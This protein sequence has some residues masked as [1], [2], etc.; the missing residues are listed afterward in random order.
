[1]IYKSE[2]AKATL[3]II[4]EEYPE[5]P[6]RWDNLGTMICFHNR[7]TI[8]DKHNYSSDTFL[9]DL[10]SEYGYIRDSYFDYWKSGPGYTQISQWV[11]SESEK[12]N[13]QGDMLFFQIGEMITEIIDKRISKEIEKHFIILPLYLYDHTG[14]TISTS[15]FSCPWDSGQVGFIFV[16]KDKVKKHFGYKH[17]TKKRINNIIKILKDEV[18]VY[19]QYLTGDIYGFKYEYKYPF[20]FENEGSSCWGFYGDNWKEN[21]LIDYLP[22]DIKP[23]IDNL[24]VE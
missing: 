21:G 7:Y 17:L 4:Q 20:S 19:D 10:L 13:Y 11:I 3:K 24:E 1:M 16:S 5:D 15:P 14:I 23:L 18:K 12:A 6:R 22:D 2:N 8:G 9:K